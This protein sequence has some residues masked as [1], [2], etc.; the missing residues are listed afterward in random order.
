MKRKWWWWNR[1]W[2]LHFI[3][4]LLIHIIIDFCY[5]NDKGNSIWIYSFLSIYIQL[6][7]SLIYSPKYYIEY[8]IFFMNEIS[9]II[10]MIFYSSFFLT[11]IFL[12]ILF[13]SIK[14]CCHLNCQKPLQ[15]IQIIILLFIL[16][17]SSISI[18]WKSYFLLIRSNIWSILSAFSY[19]YHRFHSLFFKKLLISYL[20]IIKLYFLNI[21]FYIIFS[22]FSIITISRVMNEEFES[23][24]LHKL[25]FNND[26]IFSPPDPQ[27]HSYNSLVI[28]MILQ[29]MR[30]DWKE[31][32]ICI[33]NIYFLNACLYN[34]D[35]NISISKKYSS[36]FIL[37]SFNM[38]Y[39]SMIKFILPQIIM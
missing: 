39:E 15:R 3:I 35:S 21:L 14:F 26:N 36:F 31:L 16:D 30:M 37:S 12:H 7:E 24:V 22:L 27:S 38:S 25:I 13:N 23:P 17:L 8:L 11:L 4:F 34:N 32:M 19:Y 20:I 10:S 5:S 9:L 33:R 1:I 29:Q 28:I 18:S 2:N 6:L